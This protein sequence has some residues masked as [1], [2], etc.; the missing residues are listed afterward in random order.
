MSRM[1]MIMSTV[2]IIPITAIMMPG[3]TLVPTNSIQIPIGQITIVTTI[4]I[5]GTITMEWIITRRQ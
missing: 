1:T 2:G 3:T 4:A 5:A